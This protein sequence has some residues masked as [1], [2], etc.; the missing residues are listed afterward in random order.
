MERKEGGPGT[1]L[2]PEAGGR[3]LLFEGVSRTSGLAAPP[4][5]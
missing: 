2:A 4:P 5:P 3:G 1:S